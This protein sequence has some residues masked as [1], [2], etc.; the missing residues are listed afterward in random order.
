MQDCFRQHP[1]VY[2]AELDDDEDNTEN[3]NQTIDPQVDEPSVFHPPPPAASTRS[4]EVDEPSIYQPPP[5]STL[6]INPQVDEPSRLFQDPPTTTIPTPAPPD[7]I[8]TPV[9]TLPRPAAKASKPW[10]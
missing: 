2:G 8:A 9:N 4:P 3:P 1:D 7:D 10:A 5:P 6:P